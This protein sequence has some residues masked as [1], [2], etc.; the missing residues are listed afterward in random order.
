MIRKL[1]ATDYSKYL[2][3]INDFRPTDFSEE[4]FI[5][6]LN[7]INN[8]SVIYV[9]ESEEQ[10]LATATIQYETKFIFN[11]SKLAHIED[12]CVKKEYRTQG[13]GKQILQHCIEAAKSAGAYK[14]TLDCADHNIPFYLKCGFEKRGTQMTILLKEPIS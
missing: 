9:L 3:L 12:V 8:S 10:F 11:I 4:Q 13:L 14:I 7:E 5:T 1:E 2:L 6:T